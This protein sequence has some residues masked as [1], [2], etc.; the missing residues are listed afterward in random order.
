MP[1]LDTN[2]MSVTTGFY[3][4]VS[5]PGPNDWHDYLMTRRDSK[6]KVHL[7]RIEYSEAGHWILVPVDTFWSPADAEA[8]AIFDAQKRV[9]A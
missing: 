6:G 5:I 1:K 4:H 3:R 8:A 7:N 9:T 2:K